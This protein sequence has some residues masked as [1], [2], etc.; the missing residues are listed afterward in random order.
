VR[1]VSGNVLVA[2]GECGSSPT[3]AELFDPQSETFAMT[4]GQPPTPRRYAEATLLANGQ[5][6]LSGGDPLGGCTPCPA[7]SADVYDPKL[8]AFTEEAMPDAR[9]GHTATVLPSGGVAIIGS[10]P[11][12]VVASPVADTAASAATP[13]VPGRTGGFATLLPSGKV[14]LAGGDDGTSDS[15]VSEL[16]DP[17]TN[18]F[19]KGGALDHPLYQPAIAYLPTGD[20]LLAGGRYAHLVEQ[21]ITDTS[22]YRVAA[23]TFE[24]T[25]SLATPRG[26][27]APILLPN[28]EV[29]VTG[30]FDDLTND[31]ASTEIYDAGRGTW[32]AGPPMNV[33]R[34]GHVAVPLTSGEVL[35][36]G[37]KSRIAEIFDPI[38]STFRTAKGFLAATREGPIAVLLASGDVLVVGPDFSAEAFDPGTETF[39]SIPGFT[40]GTLHAGTL[41]ASGRMF[42]EGTFGGAVFEPASATFV[43]VL[44]ASCWGEAAT[45]LPT[46]D[47][48]VSECSEAAPYPPPVLWSEYGTLTARPT[49]TSAPAGLIGGQPTAVGGTLFTARS[50]G[51]AG[52]TS[53]SAGNVPVLT[54]VSAMGD[55]V[56]RETVTSFTNTGAGL[57]PPATALAGPGVLFPSSGGVTG[58]GK[59]VSLAP[60][61]LGM[62]CTTPLD[63]ASRFCADGVCC[64]AACGTVCTACSKARK[65]AGKD[66]HCEP[67]AAGVMD[68]ECAKEAG[69]GQTG[70]C[71]GEG[72][73]SLQAL[74]TPCT[75]GGMCAQGSC[76]GALC[77]SNLDCTPGEICTTT[78]TCALP[79]VT[80]GA[81]PAVGCSI[82][83]SP[84]KAWMWR[85][86]SMVTAVA[87]RAA[88][89]R[90][91]A[92]K[93]SR[94]ARAAATAV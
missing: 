2:G 88:R 34:S 12:V 52:R 68:A 28:G 65:G 55:R 93:K 73:C 11:E 14:L 50:E 54:W 6:L 62:P 67:I 75:N 91:A 60:E 42:I 79:D 56:V 70:A 22:I 18:T 5:V 3:P 27:A 59:L 36:A 32:R 20:L 87:V 29:L 37:G 80:P 10:A 31:L 17:A 90:R 83:A 81:E 58:P 47:V 35:V 24:A 63:C 76:V 15:S 86:L 21:G 64:D 48:L 66:G 89:R 13:V 92:A 1:L 49:L 69:C 39:R 26:L 53:Q 94:S 43:P 41:L 84:A 77:T 57:T 19:A 38:A 16:Y 7:A 82:V 72:H 23:S 46:G 4:A 30:G 8:D 61:A 9:W 33:A 51:G 45:L 40:P 74:G 44:A 25:A 85:A 71:D 78:G